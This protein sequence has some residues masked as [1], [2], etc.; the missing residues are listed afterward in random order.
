[1]IHNGHK[2]INLL[3]V[4]KASVIMHFLHEWEGNEVKSAEKGGVFGKLRPRK[5]R[6]K[7][8]KTKTS[9]T[10]T[11]KTKTSKTKTSKTKT[12]KAKTLKPEFLR[13]FAISTLYRKLYLLFNVSMLCSSF[14]HAGKNLIEIASDGSSF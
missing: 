11:S 3:I 7:T 9:K 4:G 2:S 14:H 12:S 5:R 6:P 10:K 13:I 8:S 1:M